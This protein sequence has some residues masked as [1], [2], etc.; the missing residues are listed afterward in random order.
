MSLTS[1][2]WMIAMFKLRFILKWLTNIDRTSNKPIIIPRMIKLILPSEF[3]VSYLL[4]SINKQLDIFKKMY[5][6]FNYKRK[7]IECQY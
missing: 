4:K 1:D 2:I 5:F 6:S 7:G 3:L